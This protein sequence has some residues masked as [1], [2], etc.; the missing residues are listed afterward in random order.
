MLLTAILL[1]SLN[2]TVTRYILTHGFRPLA[3]ASVRYGLAAAVFALFTLVA[4]RS[5]RIARRDLPLVVG[6]ALAVWLNQLAFVYALKETSASVVGLVLGSTPI[7]AALLGLI[8]QTERLSPRFWVGAVISFLGVALV[9]AGSGGELSGSLGGILLAI[10]TA[11]TWAVY[12]MAIVPLMGRYSPGRISAV[13]LALGWVGIA[14]TGMGQSR[15]QDYGLGWEVWALLVFAT[16][17]PL[18]FTNFLWYGALHRIG[19]SRATLA[20]NLQP[21]A[22][23]LFAVVLLSESMT[24]IQVAGGACIAAGILVARRRPALTAPPSE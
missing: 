22:A 23:A 5:L 17:G 19:P 20:T 16:L 7:F 8:L 2:L 4:E 18:V 13:V 3:Y 11:L 15:D 10:A 9:A 21:F 14:L 24:A 12:S 1:W 6:A